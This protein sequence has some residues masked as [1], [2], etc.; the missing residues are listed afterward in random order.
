M[1]DMINQLAAQ[2]LG[3]AKQQIAD[4]VQQAVADKL[5]GAAQ[6]G[7][8]PAPQGAAPQGNQQAAKVAPD[9]IVPTDA[10]KASAALAPRDEGVADGQSAVTFQVEFDGEMRDLT[11]QQIRSTFDRY[12]KLNYQHQTE[13]APMKPVMDFVNKIISDAKAAGNDKVNAKDVAQFLEVAAKA[14]AKNPTMGNQSQPQGAKLGGNIDGEMA[15]WEK[16][17]QV[18]LPP[19]YKQAAGEIQAMKNMI[20]QQ[21]Q[22]INKLLQATGGVVD[23]SSAMASQAQ[24]GQVS[25]IKQQIGNNLQTAQRQLGLPD[26]AENDFMQF[27]MQRGYTIEDFIDP[28]LTMMVATDFKN[29]MNSPEMDRLR[30]IAQRRSAVTGSVEG[31]PS[32]GGT[33]PGVNPDQAF[34]DGMINNAMQN[35]FRSA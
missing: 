7:A 11:P 33:P 24:A 10:E 13:V 19:G 30:S 5:G 16:D 27:A 22:M 17:N 9:K 15:Q 35:K 8:A 6:Q 34:M 23:A 18:S 3:D 2:K 20:A 25:A 1:D 28:Q 26:E 12:S 32:A 4:K 21:N 29:N 14:Y 31:S